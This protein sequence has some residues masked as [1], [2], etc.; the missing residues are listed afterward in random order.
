MVSTIL[1]PLDGSD[2]ARCALPYA[3]FLARATHARLVL[4]HAYRSKGQDSK[5]DPELGLVMEQSDLASDLREHGVHATTWLSY[6]EPGQ[7]IVTAAADLQA[8]LIVMSTHGRGGLS[9][10]VYGSVAEQV[11]RHTSVPV[12]LVTEKCAPAWPDGLALHI[13]V[14][15]DGS[16][17][18]EQALGPA[19]EL[20]G[21]LDAD[22]VLLR[23]PESCGE[24]NTPWRP[25][26]SPAHQ[27]GQDRAQ[28]YLEDVAAP[29]RA[30]GHR[31]KARVEVGPPADVV[32]R[33]ANELNPA[34]VVMATHGRGALSPLLL[35][36]VASETLRKLMAPVLLVRP[37][38]AGEEAE[39][40]VRLGER[41]RV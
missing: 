6:D 2:L 40:T 4:L 38:Q 25:H 11:V 8:D 1:V 13:L 20:A 39:T 32:A 5:A 16:P 9:Q 14:A 12:V 33:V 15:L 41:S 10:L 22:L 19:S 17:F 35:E 36:S 26:W 7:A 23:T 3:A 29:L 18:S 21:A 24:C 31:A 30:A 28:Q 27:R 34:L 37:H